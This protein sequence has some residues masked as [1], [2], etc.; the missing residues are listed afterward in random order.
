MMDK[1]ILRQQERSVFIVLTLAILWCAPNVAIALLS[2]SLVLL[3]DIPDNFRFIFTNL[4]AW[5]ILRSIRLGS[6][7]GF[8]YG[9]D[10]LQVFASLIASI[11][12]IAALLMLAGFTIIRIINPTEMDQ[13]FTAIGASFQ[14]LLFL[15]M[16]WFWLRNKALARQQYSPVME[17]QWRINR[18][19]ALSSLV[20]FAS[21][22]LWLIL[23]DQ[24]WAVY[25]D[26]FF[27]LLFI[28]FAIASFIPTL[29]DGI[30]EMLD[31]TLQEDLQIRIDRR[32]IEHFNNYE[33]FHGVRSRRAG[34]QVFIE[35]ALSFDPDRQL[36]EVSQ[37]VASLCHAIQQ[38]VPGSEV[39]VVLV[40]CEI[41]ECTTS[42]SVEA[43]G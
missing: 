17:S 25:I 43:D 9:T 6:L 15:V 3:S 42:L 21:L 12:Y 22:M 11:T 37:T 18:A 26:P 16:G 40:P 8:D 38:D 29:M 28:C 31:K 27:A 24:P 2:G 23:K 13:E 36:G 41:L 14:F 30:N 20:C 34:G 5:R 1:E 4:L 32:L 33:G 19:D 39:R 7:Q 35:V 10:K